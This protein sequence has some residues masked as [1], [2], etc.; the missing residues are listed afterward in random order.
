[1]AIE[2][3]WDYHAYYCK[4]LIIALLFEEDT[5]TKSNFAGKFDEIGVVQNF[6]E[7]GVLNALRSDKTIRN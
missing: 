5:T 4:Y 1:M 6:L 7:R 3:A 2:K